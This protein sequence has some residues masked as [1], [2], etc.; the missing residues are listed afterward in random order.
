MGRELWP[1][2]A[3]LW[4]YVAESD[5]RRER[6]AADFARVR[7]ASG[8]KPTRARWTLRRRSPARHLIGNEIV[9]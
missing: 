7:R 8:T 9:C 5:Y 6:I 1:Y 2:A 4:P 3:Q